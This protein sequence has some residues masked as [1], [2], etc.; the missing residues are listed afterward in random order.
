M[1]LHY[2]G[3][4]AQAKSFSLRWGWSHCCVPALQPIVPYLAQIRYSFKAHWENVFISGPRSESCHLYFCG[5]SFQ[6]GEG[7]WEFEMIHPTCKYLL[8]SVFSSILY[9]RW[10]QG[11]SAVMSP[12]LSAILAHNACSIDFCLICLDDTCFL[13]LSYILNEILRV[14][15]TSINGN[16]YPYYETNKTQLWLVCLASL[17]NG[18]NNTPLG[19]L[20]K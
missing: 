10:G 16:C 4:W 13:Q 5:K 20:I 18:G 9:T 12:L 6:L 2:L 15:I 8:M 19:G 1:H 7:R 11:L 17:G 14:I 3:K